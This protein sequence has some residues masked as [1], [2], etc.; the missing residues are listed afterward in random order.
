M[1]VCSACEALSI[2]TLGCIVVLCSFG[3][4]TIP[5]P[6]SRFYASKETNQLDDIAGSRSKKLYSSPMRENA[7]QRDDI[8]G[9]KSLT[10]SWERTNVPDRSLMI[11]DIVGAR[12]KKRSGILTTK[13]HVDP[14]QPSYSLPSCRLDPPLVPKA[15]PDKEEIVTKLTKRVY[16]TKPTNNVDDIAGAKP[17]WRPT[18]V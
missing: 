14:L 10:L 13:R 18:H 12:P 8:T 4:P 2:T 9:T 17:G 7:W 5:K 6:S 3:E 1:E 11:D 16:S 15:H